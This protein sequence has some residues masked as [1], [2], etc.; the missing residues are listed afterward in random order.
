MKRMWIALLI[1]S[2]AAPACGQPA[3]VTPVP[4][5]ARSVF[6]SG[7]TAYGFFPSP[8]EVTLASVLKLYQDLGGHA[9][10][11]LIQQNVPWSDFVDRVDGPSQ[12]RT[13]I[14]NQATLARQNHLETVFVLDGLNGL[15]RSQF[16]G[17]PFGWQASFANPKIRAAYKNYALWVV[18]TFRP[19]YLGLASEINT[20]MDTHPADAQNFVTL[21]DEIYRAVKAEAPET[22]VFVTFQWE[23]LNNLIPQVADGRPRLETDW[24]RIEMFE[25]NLDVW[26]ISSYPF[27]AFQSGADIPA[28]YYARLPARTSKPLAVGEGGFTSRAV[29]PFRGAPEDQVA[30]LNAIHQQIGARLAFW[31]YLLLDDF[32]PDSY[33]KMMRANGQSS[34]DIN[35]LGMFASVGLCSLD[36]APK[37]AML[38]WDSFRTGR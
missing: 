27:V 18:R 33:G 16:S 3:L 9:D 22:R 4:T 24:D 14:A 23:E 25:P 11:V 38:L 37:P 5:P 31:V 1:L 35:T 15:N 2:L 30:Y 12:T 8:P 26:V 32:N 20:Y 36:G 7:R 6:D 29:G 13:D 34:N 10:F 19:R 28:D 21:Y 17:L